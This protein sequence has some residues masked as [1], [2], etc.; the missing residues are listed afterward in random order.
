MEFVLILTLF[1][2]W[3]V[4]VPTTEY[5]ISLLSNLPML[6]CNCFTKI[7]AGTE[8][9]IPRPV[10]NM[11]SLPTHVLHSP[12]I[13]CQ[14]KQQ[15]TSS[16]LSV[17]YG[18]TSYP[19]QLYGQIISQLLVMKI[20][21]W[22]A[23]KAIHL[24]FLAQAPKLKCL[25]L[26]HF[27]MINW[28]INTA[29][30][31]LRLQAYLICS[32]LDSGWPYHTSQTRSAALDNIWAHLTQITYN[33]NILQRNGQSYSSQVLIVS[34]ASI[35]WTQFGYDLRHFIPLWR[36]HIG[37]KKI[38]LFSLFCYHFQWVRT[39]SVNSNWL[40]SSS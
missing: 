25:F 27:N 20:L 7:S 24:R 13:Q 37:L 9:V 16:I 28:D 21:R 11:V 17:C 23:I 29:I 8:L 31:K 36:V 4:S 18:I 15:A 40:S 2:A 33:L 19:T 5:W 12:Q 14:G 34:E 22:M 32:A 30:S 35:Y 39:S 1:P 3:R 38:F 26:Y 10:S 6:S